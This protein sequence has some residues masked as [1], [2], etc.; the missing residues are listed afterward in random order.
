MSSFDTFFNAGDRSLIEV[1]PVSD[2]G[3]DRYY[4]DY[5]GVF[6]GSTG[7]EGLDLFLGGSD[8][9]ARRDSGSDLS[10][11]RSKFR[12]VGADVEDLGDGTFGVRFNA[13]VLGRR[14]ISGSLADFVRVIADSEDDLI[15][16]GDPLWDVEQMGANFFIIKRH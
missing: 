14:T 12:S 2:Y 1:E 11:L 13:S 3:S 16:V 7:S 6:S 9:H 10:S 15:N 4:A 8:G 5:A